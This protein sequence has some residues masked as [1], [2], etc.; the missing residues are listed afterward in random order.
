MDF[1]YNFNEILEVATVK[2]IGA[3]DSW[4]TGNLRCN[5]VGCFAL[6][7]RCSEAESLV[8]EWEVESLQSN[9]QQTAWKGAH[10]WVS[11][12][13]WYIA[14]HIDQHNYFPTFHIYTP[15]G[16]CCEITIVCAL[17]GMCCSC[18]PNS[19]KDFNF[20]ENGIIYEHM[21]LPLANSFKHGWLWAVRLSLSLSCPVLPLDNFFK[22]FT[23]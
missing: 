17:I 11:S 4:V 10:P 3:V 9:G 15:Q 13:N 5:E 23:P 16:I 18:Y 14:F 7:L 22:T 6:I 12:Y 19:K 8:V 2:N 20:I 21:V 1:A